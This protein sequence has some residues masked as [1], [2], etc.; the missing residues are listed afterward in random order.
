MDTSLVI[1]WTQE[2]LRMALLLAGPPLLAALVVG[3]LIG[4]G[5]TITQMHEPVVAQI[6]R[7]LA[8]VVV[9]LLVLPWLLGSWVSYASQLIGTLPDRMFS[10]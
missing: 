9:V 8:V 10:G 6:P 1:E 4:A 7:L 2:A 5:Q 3:L